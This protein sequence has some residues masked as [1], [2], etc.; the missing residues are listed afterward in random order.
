[1][2]CDAAELTRA[3]KFLLINPGPNGR[4]MLP[5]VK[6][7]NTII[8]DSEI[9]KEASKLNMTQLD[10]IIRIRAC[11]HA[12]EAAEREQRRLAA[13]AGGKKRSHRHKHG[14]RNTRGKRKRSRRTCRR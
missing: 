13:A 1:M 14:R 6:H 10:Y 12:A 9:A 3:R 5:N 4:F 8:N 2:E 11:V 7:F